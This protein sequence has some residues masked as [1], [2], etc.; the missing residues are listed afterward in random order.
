MGGR[1][2]EGQCARLSVWLACLSLT[3]RVPPPLLCMEC[4]CCTGIDACACLH[5]CVRVDPRWR[6]LRIFMFVCSRYLLLFPIT[7]IVLVFYPSLFLLLSRS[8]VLKALS[9]LW[10]VCVCVRAL[11]VVVFAVEENAN[12]CIQIC[13]VY[14]ERGRYV[15]TYTICA[16]YICT[17]LYKEGGSVCENE[18]FF[19]VCLACLCEEVQPLCTKIRKSAEHTS[20]VR[21]GKKKR[22]GEGKGRGEG[23]PNAVKPSSARVYVAGRS[24][25]FVV[26]LA[27]VALGAVYP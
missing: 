6:A 20:K 24:F 18:A 16:L 15:Y 13:I 10:C 27:P 22:R 3:F 9:C 12:V 2:L 7:L 5:P 14:R 17:T 19:V 8:R 26:F 11:P 4:L 25:L 23:R 21:A 1:V